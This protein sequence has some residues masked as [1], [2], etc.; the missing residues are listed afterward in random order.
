LPAWRRTNAD[1]TRGGLGPPHPFHDGAADRGPFAIFQWE[2]QR[3]SSLKVARTAA[4]NTI[5]ACEM[6]YLLN[7]R[8]HVDHALRL[9]T[10]TGN[11]GPCW[12]C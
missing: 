2:L 9:D 10:L 5:V 3:G 6:F 7:V 12:C 8:R 1:Q 4:V 11:R